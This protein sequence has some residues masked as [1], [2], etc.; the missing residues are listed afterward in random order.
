MLEL[1]PL[2]LGEKKLAEK[3]APRFRQHV[4]HGTLVIS[5]AHL[6][7]SANLTLPLHLTEPLNCSVHF[8]QVVLARLHIQR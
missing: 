8:L 2:G 5:E 4:Y 3:G 1:V 7:I 6:G